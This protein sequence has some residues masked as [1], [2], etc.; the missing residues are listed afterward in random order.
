MNHKLPKESSLVGFINH[1]L[2]KINKNQNQYIHNNY[3]QK[4]K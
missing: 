4:H 2:F 1:V 3:T